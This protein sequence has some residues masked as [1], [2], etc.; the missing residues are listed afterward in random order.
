[1]MSLWIGLWPTAGNHLAGSIHEHGLKPTPSLKTG[2]RA[3]LAAAAA[4]SE[5]ARAAGTAESVL[6]LTGFPH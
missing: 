3:G 6:A 2:F 5:P 4:T 1:M